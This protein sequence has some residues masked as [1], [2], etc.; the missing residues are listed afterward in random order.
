MTI[1]S[2][3]YAREVLDSRGN[4]TVEVEVY[5]EDGASGG[6]IVP[7]GASTGAFE[8]VELRDGD[9][10]RYL[11]RGVKKA[12]E[13]VN[14]I[15]APEIIGLDAVEQTLIDRIMIDLDGTQNKGRLGANAVLGVSIAVAKAAACALG[16]PLFQ[17]LGGVNAKQLPVP[18]MNILNGGA[19]ADNNLDIQEFMIMPVGAINFSDGLRMCVEIY[20]NLKSVLREKGLSTGVGDEGG[21][22]PDLS[23]NEEALQIIVEAVKSAGYGPGQDIKLALDV[24]ATELYDGN[25]KVYKLSGEGVTKTAEEMVDFYEQLINKYPI[26]SIE[27]GLSEDDWDGWNLMTNKLGGRIQ[28]V[29]DDL[30]VTNTERLARGIQEETAN[31]ILIKL[32]QIGTIT[33]TLDAIEM[34]KRAGYTAVIS[35]RS[36]ESEDTTIADVAVAV[37]AGQIKTGAPARTDRV[38]KYNRLLRIEDILGSASEYLGEKVFYNLNNNS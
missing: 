1:I 37:N 22:A 17:Y 15:I 9:K 20:H 26:I 29:G 36:G 8:A 7:S 31:S 13:N 2:D 32:N 34:A 6:A 30:F 4:P 5:L 28:I 14:E 24:A 16:L 35:H 38:A 23:T 18:M 10:G 12:V 25:K 21:F 3:V 27:D 11:G 33:E 19:H